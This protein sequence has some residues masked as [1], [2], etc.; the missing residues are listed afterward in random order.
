MQT[1]V[2]F[3]PDLAILSIS[4]ADQYRRLGDVGMAITTYQQALGWFESGSAAIAPG[5]N[6]RPGPTGRIRALSYSRLAE[7]YEDLGQV[8]TARNSYS[9]RPTLDPGDAG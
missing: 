8:D 5:G 1:A 7:L 2:E 4:L 3:N 9:A 6:S